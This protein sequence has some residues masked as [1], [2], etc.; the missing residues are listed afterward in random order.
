MLHAGV[1]GTE[2]VHEVTHGVW[3]NASATRVIGPIYF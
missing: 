2:I 1:V 3:R